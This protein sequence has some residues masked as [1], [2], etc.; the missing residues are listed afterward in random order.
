MSDVDRN[1]MRDFELCLSLGS[2]AKTVNLCRTSRNLILR[3]S[4]TL[5]SDCRRRYLWR[6]VLPRTDGSEGYLYGL[7]HCG[8]HV[9]PGVR[10]I[11]V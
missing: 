2:G 9:L 7:T 3:E 5:E 8:G 6:T 10:T 11:E 1:L 4:D